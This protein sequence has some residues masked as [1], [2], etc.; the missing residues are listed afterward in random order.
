[1]KEKLYRKGII[2]K[3]ILGIELGSTR[4]KAVLT[5]EC[6][7]V[8][9]QGAYEWENQLVDGLWS[10]ALADVETGLQASFAA[11]AADYRAKFGEPLTEL[12][13]L[14]I[15]AM[16]HGYLAFDEKDVLLVP[17]RTWRNTNTEQAANELTELLSFNIPMRW[18]VSHFY[19]AVLSG[20][21]HVK[22]VSH[23]NTLSGYVHYRLTGRRV[24]GMGDASGMFPVSGGTYDR[25]MAEKFDALLAEKGVDA[26][27]AALFPTVLA[28]GED[29][30]V[31]T[32][33]GA[34]FLDPTG[35]LRPG[36]ILC[37]P[38]GDAGTGMVA[39]NSV[40]TGTANVSAG[41]SGFLMAVL[42][43]PLSRY[44]PEI[45]VVTTPDGAPTAMVHVN[46]FASEIT[47]WCN[48]FA[49]V[50]ALGGGTPDRNS[51]FDALYKK[52]AEADADCGGL[53]GYNFLAAEPISGA[54]KGLL[55]IARTPDGKLSLANF[56]KMHI[57]S[58]LGSLA[59]GC[60]ILNRENVK[61]SS[62]CGHGGFF[63]TPVVGQS[64][65]SAAVGA[66][67]TVMSNAGE[68]GAWGIAVLALYALEKNGTLGDFLDRIFAD[69]ASTTV[70]ADE[71]EKAAFG[72]FMKQYKAGL[73]AQKLAAEVL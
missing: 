43:Q 23:I 41:T 21:A 7:A 48:L 42:N 63:K 46:N 73:G 68:G 16:M 69:A 35:T 54:D 12:D 15:S 38:E 57:Y 28:A 53:V 22:D 40:R 10:Y 1:M 8:I 13:A 49:E 59:I 3:K 47:A 25:E 60:E 14:G 70:F 52:S 50:I 17:F 61:I 24:L 65:M 72:R 58:S 5:D 51:L 11:L 71:A 9:A 36:A 19:Q 39:T 6:A 30:G 56:M 26:H 4:I 37:P 18:S 64:A 44:Y 62:V 66:P 27:L 45:D 31:L 32:E 55:M 20:E 33:E 29:A 2:M 34:A 67:V